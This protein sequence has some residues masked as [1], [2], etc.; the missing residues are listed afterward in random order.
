M[1]IT[2]LRTILVDAPA[3]FAIYGER[4]YPDTL[5]DAPTYPAGVLTKIGGPGQYDLEGDVGVERSRVQ[6][7]LHHADGYAAA[8]G[9]RRAVR[10]ILSGYRGGPTSALA[11]NVQ[12]MF[13]IN[14]FDLTEPATE[15]AGPRVRRRVLEFIVWNREA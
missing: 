5:P 12:G 3:V 15:R 1:I 10:E 2:T 13:C 6:V 14:D 8:S 7:D 11:C 4:W 9:G